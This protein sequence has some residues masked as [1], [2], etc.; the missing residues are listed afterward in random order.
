M[1][2]NCNFCLFFC[3]CQ[4]VEQKKSGNFF[5]LED[6]RHTLRTS[7]SHCT[8]F[9]S[10]FRDALQASKVCSI[11]S[12][13]TYSNLLLFTKEP[14]RFES[15]TLVEGRSGSAY[16][17]LFINNLK[18]VLIHCIVHKDR[19][20]KYFGYILFNH[21]SLFTSARVAY[22]VLLLCWWLDICETLTLRTVRLLL[23]KYIYMQYSSLIKIEN[24]IHTSYMHVLYL[25]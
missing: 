3:C 5:F 25:K 8:V 7:T 19:G 11:L 20:V 14:L 18:D 22:T 1:C 10:H 2:S 17:V 23:W 21:D 13:G 9:S 24:I 16:Y 12:Y 15:V 4:D 6:W